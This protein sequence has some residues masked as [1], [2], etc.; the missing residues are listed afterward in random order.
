[1][2]NQLLIR[3]AMAVLAMGLPLM[4]ETT[5]EDI[6]KLVNDIKKERV[7]LTEEEI[8]KAKDPFLYFGS[9]IYK[10]I[11]HTKKRK[12]RYHFVLS[13]IVN[14]S[15]KLNNRWYSK[16]DKIYGFVIASV[17]KDYVVLK[18]R[19]QTVRVYIKPPVNK[20]IKLLVK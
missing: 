8:E 16:N 4:A 18:K 5:I 13:A 10:K 20:K 1:M 9:P 11:V 2:G 19:N 15:V 6:D 14:D 3:T 17:G 7:G 12:K